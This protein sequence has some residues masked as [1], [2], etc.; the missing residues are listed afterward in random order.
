[1]V[2][3]EVVDGAMAQLRAL[4]PD[5]SLQQEREQG[6]D[7]V[8]PESDFVVEVALEALCFRIVGEV[9]EGESSAGLHDRMQRV[10][11][12]SESIPDALGVIAAPYLSAHRRAMIRDAGLGYVDLSGNAYLR[13]GSLLVMV[14]GEPNRFNRESGSRG[15]FSGKASLVPELL[16]EQVRPWGI[17]ELASELGLDPGHVSRIVAHLASASYVSKGSDG[18]VS[19]ARPEELLGDWAL[20][21]KPPKGQELL[22]FSQSSS[23]SQIIDRLCDAAS[24][25]PHNYALGNQAGA[26]LVAPYAAIDRVDV[27]LGDHDAEE[28][29]EQALELRA[30][31]RGANVVLHLLA[32]QDDAVLRRRRRIDGLWVVSDC[33]LYLD[34]LR[35]PRRGVEQAEHLLDVVL[36]PRWDRP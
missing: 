10:R 15:P 25:A 21:Y 8:Y 23:P 13:H 2:R 5:A 3:N 28:W 6:G 35:Y 27:Y 30:V 18:K 22:R 34:L 14:E 26:S 17:R 16:L 4:I 1:M 20:A 7:S 32:D 29:L 31:E 24:D 36:R 12:A 9:Y 33:R 19:L 11:V